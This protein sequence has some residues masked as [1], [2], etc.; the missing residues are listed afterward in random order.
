MSEDGD[1]GRSVVSVHT[2]EIATALAIIA[3][4][5]VVMIANYRL[6]AG[7][8]K[9]G[10]ESGYFPF[11]V[12][13]LLFLSGAGILIG[14]LV[15]GGA[16]G[17]RSFVASRPLVRVV[18]IV[19]PTVIFVIAIVFI[20]IYVATAVFIAFFMVWL[21]RYRVIVAVP[22]G[23]AIAAALFLTFEVWFLVPLPKGPLEA[24]LGY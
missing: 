21:G 19:V 6:G 12:G 13:V 9:N 18:Q 4:A 1:T 5:G 22:L 20:G 7:W 14:E 2:M 8:D 11:Y 10:P 16:G 23:V 15:K 17:S 24:L 3:F